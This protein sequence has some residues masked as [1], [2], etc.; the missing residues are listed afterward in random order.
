MTASSARADAAGRHR[1]VQGLR[2][3]AM[4]LVVVSHGWM[5]VPYEGWLDGPA[6]GVL[7][8][9]NLAVT[10]FLVLAGYFLVRSLLR[11]AD[12]SG[13]VDVQHTL[14]SR[15]ARLSVQT[16]PLV[17]AMLAVASLAPA[18]V[19]DQYDNPRSAFRVLT[20][21]WN[22]FAMDNVFSSRPDLGH[23]W[24]A[25][26]Y[27][28]VAVALVFLVALARRH[29]VALAT[30]LVVA[31]AVVTAWRWW[32]V[33]NE[34]LFVTLLR[35]STRM[36]GMLWGALLA[37]VQPWLRP[38]RGR[39]GAAVASAS[40]L[41][42][43]TLVAVADDRTYFTW[44][45]LLA[46]LASCALLLSLVSGSSGA[47]ADLLRLRP[48]AALGDHAFAVYIWHFA[49]FWWVSK[50][51]PEW[52]AGAKVA[53]GLAATGVIVVL[54]DRLLERP[55]GRWL[56]SRRAERMARPQRRVRERTGLL[57]P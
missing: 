18:G 4:V 13:R 2:G 33:G 35:T 48:L 54:T 16:Y 55:L 38:L 52:S 25:S 40:L 8:G 21:T 14:L 12:T 51:V 49:V 46:C 41:V 53:L 36:D 26:V 31:V 20:Y 28:Q 5:L 57:E 44:A 30:V 56:D 22:W 45:G 17:L 39:G 11:D 7:R 32:S 37:T 29:R 34:E 6:R 23:L 19:Y 42:L 50:E 27:L 3:L 15:W 47:A 43:L 9:G 10:V 24:F 1:S